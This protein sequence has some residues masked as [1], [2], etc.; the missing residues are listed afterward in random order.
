MI[1]GEFTLGITPVVLYLVNLLRRKRA[2]KVLTR[3]VECEAELLLYKKKCVKSILRFIRAEYIA[4]YGYCVD[5]YDCVF[6]KKWRNGRIGSVP[7]NLPVYFL[8]G[9]CYSEV[10]DADI[11]ILV[12]ALIC[13]GV[14]ITEVVG[15]AFIGRS[16]IFS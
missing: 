8:D 7:A 3:G 2:V 1:R 11:P 15:G 6:V 9:R 16:L 14:V 4:F 5:G 13:L 12:E 10:H